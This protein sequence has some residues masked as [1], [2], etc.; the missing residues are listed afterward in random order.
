VTSAAVAAAR[1][2]QSIPSPGPPRGFVPQDGD[3]NDVDPEIL[4]ELAVLTEPA[5][6]PRASRLLEASALIALAKT[7]IEALDKEISRL[8]GCKAERA[9][10]VAMVQAAG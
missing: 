1:I 7:R 2:S 9:T 4:E 6:A 8:E 3:T 5:P 10:L